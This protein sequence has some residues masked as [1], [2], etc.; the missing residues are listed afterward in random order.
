MRGRLTVRGGSCVII[1][2]T[3]GFS[4]VQE[5]QDVTIPTGETRTDLPRRY[6][7]MGTPP[8]KEVTYMGEKVKSQL[9]IWLTLSVL[10]GAITRL[11]ETLADILR[12]LI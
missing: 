1:S 3:N 8:R 12:L 5:T 2:C 9:I 10:L 6:L 7:A 11:L 4:M